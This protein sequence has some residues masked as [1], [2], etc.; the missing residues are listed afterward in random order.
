M[1]L[2]G[3]A[4]SGELKVQGSV[5]STFRPAYDVLVRPKGAKTPL[6]RSQGLVRDNYLSGIF[7][8]ITLQRW[9]K[10]EKLRGVS[11]AAPIANVGYTAAFAKLQ[12]FPT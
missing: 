9:H 7:G 11:V 10:I 4:R 5:Q 12:E 3:S 1:L 2:I 6:E 8:G